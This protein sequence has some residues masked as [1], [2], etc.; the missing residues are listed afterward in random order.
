M[1]RTLLAALAALCLSLP[2]AAGNIPITV[3]PPPCP[4]GQTCTT[5]AAPNP[6]PEDEDSLLENILDLFLG[7]GD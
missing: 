2:V 5:G 7:E 3:D 4:E 1:K 6:E